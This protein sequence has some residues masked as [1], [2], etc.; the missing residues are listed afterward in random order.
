MPKIHLLDNSILFFF[1]QN[2]YKQLKIFALQNMLQTDKLEE[3]II[4]RF[5]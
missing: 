5:L 2:E 4:I 1:K 3:M